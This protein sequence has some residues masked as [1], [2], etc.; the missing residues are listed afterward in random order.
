MRLALKD[1]FLFDYKVIIGCQLQIKYYANIL[2][3]IET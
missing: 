3:T 2:T 1:P